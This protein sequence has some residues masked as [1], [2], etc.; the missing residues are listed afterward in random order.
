MPD[1]AELPALLFCAVMLCWMVFAATFL[2]RRRPKATGPEARR[3]P[4][5]WAGILLQGAAYSLVWMGQR[6]PMPPKSGFLPLPALAEVALSLLTFAVAV[7]SVWLTV[8]AV[9]T[10]GKQW[11]LPARLVEGHKLITTGPYRLVRNPIYTGMFGLLLATGVA[12]SRPWALAAATGIF[13]TGTW[14]RVRSE[15]KLLTAAFGQEFQD[16]KART[17]A[18]L[19]G[20]F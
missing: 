10:L 7:A 11:A 8:T 2:L 19:P 14:V 5:S 16:Y 13:L 1:L 9:R 4:R 12:V 6:A 15:E 20:L 3:D 18:L 17:A